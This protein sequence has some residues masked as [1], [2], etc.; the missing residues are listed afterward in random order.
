M[1]RTGISRRSFI[2]MEEIKPVNQ[3]IPSHEKQ[4]ALTEAQQLSDEIRNIFNN[5]HMYSFSMDEYYI[6]YS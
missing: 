2:F 5:I 1:L 4:R 3:A 6:I